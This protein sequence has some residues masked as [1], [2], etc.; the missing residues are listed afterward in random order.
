[1]GA[2]RG[3]L[4][5]EKVI[6]EN[7]KRLLELFAPY[8][9]LKGINSAI[10]RKNLKYSSNN[11]EI[12]INIP[13]WMFDDPLIKQLH[14]SGS[15]EA[16]LH[17]TGQEVSF[18]TINEIDTYITQLRLTQDFEFWA[19]TCA[20]IQD[21]KS[22][23]LIPFKLNRPQRRYL[24]RLE[25]MRVAGVPIR[26]IVLKARQWGGSTLTQMYMAWIQLRHKTRW[27]SAIVTDIEE[28]AKN[29]RNM[30]VTMSKS[31]PKEVGT[32]TLGPYMGSSK[33]KTIAERDCII[34]LGS[35]QQPD[36]LRSFDFAMIHE[37]EVGLWKD[38]MLRKAADL[39]QTLQATVPDEPYTLVVMESTAKGM[40]NYFHKQWQ[41]AEAGKSAFDHI[42]VPWFEIELYVKEVEDHKAFISTWT[43]YQ[44]E[45]WEQ[46]ATIE[47]I[48]WYKS[49]QEGYDYDD[50]RMQ[51]EYPGTAQEA[52]QSTGMRVFAP[53]YVANARKTC[54]KA[55]FVGDISADGTKGAE[56]FNNIT[57]N[58]HTK[59]CLSIWDKPDL[60][61]KMD[62]RY[63]GFVD[64]GGRHDGADYSVIKI[65]DRYWMSEDGVPEVVAVWHGHLDQDLLAWKAAQLAAWY[66]NAHLAV[67]SNSLKKDK[68]D[69]DHFLTILDEIVDFYPN[70]Y[71]RD[72]IEQVQANIPRKYGFHTNMK[73]K[74]QIIDHLNAALR[75]EGYIERD[76][77]ACDEM[78]QYETK[79][80]GSIG[81][82]DGGHDDHVI[83]TAGGC[84]LC[85]DLPRP[86]VITHDM[87]YKLRTKIR[88]EATM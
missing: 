22:K 57:F 44:W 60:S 15:V 6:A 87:K 27:H 25:K 35:A 24:A 64:I 10:E 34:G 26:M 38:T 72:D 2:G 65:F 83:V 31:Y 55:E 1:M 71:A 69:G 54:R 68:K 48:Y 36:S 20:K 12:S 28:Q 8:N 7:K 3:S 19:F 39:S 29:I 59:G 23:Q 16:I 73:T 88:S 18:E 30:Y 53:R 76:T 75:E 5:V 33:S 85:Y 41:N 84:W 86:K 45:Q 67:E 43:D 66:N 74:P 13:I 40:G 77:R 50:W 37:S 42:F 14:R 62:N 47:G 56:A 52:F 78:D 49:T 21:K 82:I 17:L 61:I 11:I 51:S 70:L 81:A 63:V 58:E 80:D 32:I 9:P 79:P 46:G 4:S